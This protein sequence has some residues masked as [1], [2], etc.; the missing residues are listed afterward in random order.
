M[1]LPV[2]LSALREDFE[3]RGGEVTLSGVSSLTGGDLFRRCST[4]ER[5]HHRRVVGVEAK[6]VS[7]KHRLHTA[8]GV[9]GRVT[10]AML[11]GPLHLLQL[12]FEQKPSRGRAIGDT[13]ELAGTSLRRGVHPQA[14]ADGNSFLHRSLPSTPFGGRQAAIPAEFPAIWAGLRN[15]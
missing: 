7:E 6:P 12:P 10:D 11:M 3:A 14:R 9:G 5:H 1:P 2:W 13:D 8:P 4:T 15:K